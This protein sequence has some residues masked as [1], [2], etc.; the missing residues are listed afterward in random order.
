MEL[1]DLSY[2][3]ECLL[4]LPLVVTKYLEDHKTKDFSQALHL[5]GELSIGRLHSKQL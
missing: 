4:I 2:P 3:A 5:V 1:I